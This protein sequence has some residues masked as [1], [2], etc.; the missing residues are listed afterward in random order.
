[1]TG[2]QSA[3][4]GDRR[5]RKKS[6]AQREPLHVRYYGNGPKSVSKHMTRAKLEALFDRP[7]E[8]AARALGVSSTIIKRLCRRHG[9]PKWPYR[10]LLRLETQIAKQEQ[11]LQALQEQAAV[12]VLAVDNGHSASARLRDRIALLREEKTLIITGCDSAAA[13][14]SASSAA[15]YGAAAAAA[16][17]RQRRRTSNT[18]SPSSES[19]NT[20][21][22]DDGGEAEAAAVTAAGRRLS[23]RPATGTRRPA[24]L[25]LSAAASRHGD[26][27]SD[28]ESAISEYAPLI[29]SGPLIVKP[30]PWDTDLPFDRLGSDLQVQLASLS[31]CRQSTGSSTSQRRCGSRSATSRAAAPAPAA[32]TAEATVTRRPSVKCVS[33]ELGSAPSPGPAALVPLDERAPPAGAGKW[34]FA[35][36]V[37]PGDFQISGD[38]GASSG[39]AACVGPP[40]SWLA[41]SP[42]AAPYAASPAAHARWLGPSTAANP[43]HSAAAERARCGGGGVALSQWQP[44]GGASLTPLP[45]ARGSDGIMSQWH[46]VDVLGGGAPPATPWAHMLEAA[47]GSSGGGPFHAL[48]PASPLADSGGPHFGFCSTSDYG[49]LGTSELLD[50]FLA[51]P[52]LCARLQL[53]ACDSADYYR[54]LP[55]QIVF[56]PHAARARPAAALSCPAIQSPAAAAQGAAAAAALNLTRC[57]HRAALARARAAAAAAAC[58]TVFL[59]LLHL[60]SWLY[61][62]LL[63]QVMQLLVLAYY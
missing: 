15:D 26:A 58:R 41:A 46:G 32:A 57:V 33:P 1:M 31:V 25:R 21:S 59:R 44:D 49:A 37:F 55:L 43:A 7:V 5:A 16:R 3:M 28:S 40:Q 11:I 36:A 24:R 19:S 4:R 48:P 52:M 12:S 38:G 56:E 18:T 6:P 13:S 8:H 10:Q 9:I 35:P 20:G 34:R 22:S 39:R 50:S 61:M 62:L 54:Y 17:R 47:H 14:D 60:A 51:D 42:L 29:S 23:C 27:N 2:A 45:P 53:K 63:Q 30:E